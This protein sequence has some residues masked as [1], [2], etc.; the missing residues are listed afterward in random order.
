MDQEFAE[1]IY[2][3]VM[4][5]LTNEYRCREVEDLFEEG[6][7]CQVLY[8]QM[9]DAYWRLCERLGEAEEE[10]DDD[11]ECMVNSML[12]ITK[13]VGI[14]MFECGQRFCEK[15]QPCGKPQG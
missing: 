5:N 8:S 10:A 3:S 1:W 14:K 11:G 12:A 2:D 7:T 13:I 6:K 4:G 9:L 15:N